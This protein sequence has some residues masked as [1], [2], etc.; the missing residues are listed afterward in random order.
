MSIIVNALKLTPE[1][2]ADP[3]AAAEVLRTA[4]LEVLHR[5]RARWVQMGIS[6]GQSPYQAWAD[7]WHLTQG[8]DP[9]IDSTASA[10]LV[11]DR[12]KVYAMVFGPHNTLSH[13]I[14]SGLGTDFS[15]DSR[16]GH[17]PYRTWERIFDAQGPIPETMG[18][19]VHARI[20][21]MDGL[22]QSG[23][24]GE[25]VNSIPSYVKRWAPES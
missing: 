12:R 14:D 25:F 15:A 16:V 3:W 6:R 7:A 10:I 18:L 19:S 23:W 20:G 5:E 1:L 21:F 9:S 22:D 24:G 2:S 4:M 11:R 17:G 8:H 13:L